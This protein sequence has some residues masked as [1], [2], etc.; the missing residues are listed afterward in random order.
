MDIEI[1]ERPSFDMP[2]CCKIPDNVTMQNI[3]GKS[4]FDWRAG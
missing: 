3:G 4:L 2:L 1:P